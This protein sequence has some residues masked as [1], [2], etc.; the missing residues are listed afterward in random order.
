MNPPLTLDEM[1]AVVKHKTIT[2]SLM[3]ENMVAD[4]RMGAAH[5]ERF[6]AAQR[7]VDDALAILRDVPFEVAQ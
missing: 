6:T 3:L 1:Y 2:L 4:E 5:R 7:L